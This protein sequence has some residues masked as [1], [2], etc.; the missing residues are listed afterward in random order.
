MGAAITA[1]VGVGL[2]PDFNVI[3]RFLKITEELTPSGESDAVY[4][5]AKQ[6]F[7]DAYQALVPIFQEL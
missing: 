3:D 4:A 6:V 7:E 2:Y 5:H 1:G